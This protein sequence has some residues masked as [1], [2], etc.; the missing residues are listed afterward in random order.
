ML[1]ILGQLWLGQ[2]NKED[3]MMSDLHEGDEPMAEQLTA[4]S[5]KELADQ[6]FIKAAV[7]QTRLDALV[8][9]AVANPAAR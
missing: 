1:A 7:E 6:E 4:F 3:I 9:Q 8:E 5:K 2:N